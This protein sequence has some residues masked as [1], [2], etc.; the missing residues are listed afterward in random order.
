MTENEINELNE[1]IN[2]G[3]KEE[4]INA[5]GK[6]LEY[7]KSICDD[8]SIAQYTEI[9]ENLNSNNTEREEKQNTQT[10]D[11][12]TWIN[13]YYNHIYSFMRIKEL[14]E[15]MEY[16]P[17][18][19]IVYGKESFNGND[20]KTSIVAF[21][22]AIKLLDK[23]AKKEQNVDFTSLLYDVHVNLGD[24]YYNNQEYVKAKM[25]YDNAREVSFR[26]YEDENNVALKRLEMMYANGIGCEK[27]LKKANTIKE[28]YY[29]KHA[30]TCFQR[31][32]EYSKEG[33]KFKVREW[34]ENATVAPDYKEDSDLAKKIEDFANQHEIK[35][36]KPIEKIDLREPTINLN[37]KSNNIDT[38]K[39]PIIDNDE[40]NKELTQEEINELNDLINSGEVEETTKAAKRLMQYYLAIG[41]NT[42]AS[43]YKNILIQLSPEESVEEAK[44]EEQAITDVQIPPYEAWSF[45]F[46][47]GLY[48]KMMLKDL[49]KRVE[50]DP[51]ACV[52]YASA[53]YNSEE[54]DVAIETY[55]KE[56][57][58]FERINVENK[59]CFPKF[60]YDAYTNL[61]ASYYKKEN[62]KKA[63]H[64]FQNA[65]EI[66]YN[67]EQF[68]ASGNLALM[69][70]NGKGCKLDKDKAV[71]LKKEYCL[72]DA[73]E[74]FKIALMYAEKN[75]Y[76]LTKEWVEYA[77]DASNYGE[78]DYLAKEVN[79]LASKVEAKN[80]KGKSFS[81]IESAIDLYNETELEDEILKNV[82]ISIINALKE[83]NNNGRLE[84]FAE[85]HKKGELS[86]YIK[87]Y[88]DSTKKPIK[89]Q[90]DNS[91]WTNTR[92]SLQI[93]IDDSQIFDSLEDVIEHIN[94]S[95]TREQLI[96]VCEQALAQGYTDNR[97][98]DAMIDQYEAS[99][100]PNRIQKAYEM[101]EEAYFVTHNT[102]NLI[103]L[104]MLI[105]KS[106]NNVSKIK[107][108]LNEEKKTDDQKNLNPHILA[109]GDITITLYEE[110]IFKAKSKTK[111][112][113]KKFKEMNLS[114]SFVA[115]FEKQISILIPKNERTLNKTSD[116]TL[117][118]KLEFDEKVNL[119][120]DVVKILVLSIFSIVIGIDAEIAPFSVRITF[121]LLGVL[122]AV[123]GIFHI[124]EYREES[125]S[126][127]AK[128]GVFF[129]DYFWLWLVG[130]FIIGLVAEY[131]G[132]E[133]LAH[134]G[135]PQN[136]LEFMGQCAITVIVWLIF[137][138][139]CFGV[140]G[141]RK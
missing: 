130:I 31:A 7:Y 3:T 52:E 125:K 30:D 107:K 37:T 88:F 72:N 56:I 89:E 57:L 18:A 108:I 29:I 38:S 63:F 28:K 44:T 73:E 92:Y 118:R 112:Y 103:K 99:N 97:I 11:F 9:I 137:I 8:E 90:N 85:E 102:Y 132:K 15:R 95:A 33:R 54:Y 91:F 40:N 138:G 41:D 47:Y 49:Q 71:A 101:Y 26:K 133:L 70:E 13:N 116:E 135:N 24:A 127:L 123:S 117:K 96:S 66:N 134:G 46:E 69:Y 82:K 35:L 109:L 126:S 17:F 27:D 100:I 86:E 65:K 94:N 60:I 61:G 139:I 113:L 43:E 51:F 6:L 34:L 140:A 80:S 136:L 141:I 39:A 106:K 23:Y 10:D 75:K 131:S 1:Q 42:Q 14:T 79:Y 115:Y 128:I 59:K 77:L 68:I 87:D 5:A 120:F 12:A 122:I 114:E 62:Y 124:K 98:Y 45:N 48:G 129:T 83:K 121:G 21:N 16:D 2:S 25:N 93:E 76:M 74:C 119:A 78:E 50:Y 64:S 111:K 53:A 32:E 67:D 81:E 110:G 19:C 4:A 84:K 22:N 20:Y 36:G 104:I 55:E 105:E 58:L